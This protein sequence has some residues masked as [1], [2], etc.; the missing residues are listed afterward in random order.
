[1]ANL[2]Q[3]KNER[4]ARYGDIKDNSEIYAFLM[5]KIIKKRLNNEIDDT[6]FHI[7]G[8]LS[9][10]IARALNGDINYDDNYVDMINYCQLALDNLPRPKENRL[11]SVKTSKDFNKPL[12]I[13]PYKNRSN[14]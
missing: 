7:W 2:E 14:K 11:E 1:M 5:D 10:K 9:T 13:Y 4:K 6:L 12:Y 8:N 3:I